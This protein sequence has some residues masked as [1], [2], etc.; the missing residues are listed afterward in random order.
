MTTIKGTRCAYVIGQFHCELTMRTLLKNFLLLSSI[1]GTGSLQALPSGAEVKKLLSTNKKQPLQSLQLTIIGDSISAGAL[2]ATRLGT[3]L[4]PELISGIVAAVMARDP[5]LFLSATLS[6]QSAYPEAQGSWSLKQLLLDQ[7]KIPTARLSLDNESA[8]GRSMSNVTE[9]LLKG[10][11]EPKDGSTEHHI[12]LM[13]GSNDFCQGKSPEGFKETSSEV[14]GRLD[15]MFPKAKIFVAEVPPIY[16]LKNFGQEMI[17][18][19]VSCE[20]IQ[21]LYCDRVYATDAESVN[22]GYNEGLK[23]LV[24]EANKKP[25]EPRYKFIS[26]PPDLTLDKTLLS[27]DC[28]HPG[29]EGHK[30]LAATVVSQMTTP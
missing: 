12:L 1:L 23:K 15:R 30:K 26:M 10:L 25:G 6:P 28:F 20:A 21:R 14:F 8:V 19:Q 3:A 24:A 29:E 2:A 18:G 4:S 9:N 16:Q 17:F 5:Q 11:D 13:L 7:Y 22:R 27:S